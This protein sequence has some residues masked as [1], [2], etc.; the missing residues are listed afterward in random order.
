MVDI[1]VDSEGKAL[2]IGGKTI[3]ASEGSGGGGSGVTDG[4]FW[5]IVPNHSSNYTYLSSFIINGT[6]YATEIKNAFNDTE[7]IGFIKYHKIKLPLGQNYSYTIRGSN[8]WVPEYGHDSGTIYFTNNVSQLC[9]LRF[10][11]E[12]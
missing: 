1:L 11:E 8:G 7:S 9:A 2:T 12:A 6:D 3:K 5:V 10:E 4:E